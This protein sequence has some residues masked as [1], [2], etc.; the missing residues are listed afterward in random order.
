MGQ[1]RWGEAEEWRSS[2]IPLPPPTFAS[3]YVCS[4]FETGAVAGGAAAAPLSVTANGE[5][6]PVRAVYPPGVSAR[7]VADKDTWCTVE[8]QQ[9]GLS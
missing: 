4:V 9:S 2:T 3:P 6:D 5:K 1:G 8:A 7:A